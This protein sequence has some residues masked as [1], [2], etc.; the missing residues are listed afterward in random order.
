MPCIESHQLS[1]VAASVLFATFAGTH[2]LVA[3]HAQ[4]FYLVDRVIPLLASFALPPFVSIL[5]HCI[6]S[7]SILTESRLLCPSSCIILFVRVERL[8]AVYSIPDR[9]EGVIGGG[10]SRRG[11]AVLCAVYQCIV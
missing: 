11:H 10:R 6:R 4:R 8:C 7:F 2:L 3:L 9:L 5:I 1:L